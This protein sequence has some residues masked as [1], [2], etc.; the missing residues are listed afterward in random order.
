[1]TGTGRELLP[2]PLTSD[3]EERPMIHSPFA[4]LLNWY[5]TPEFVVPVLPAFGGAILKGL[6][7]RSRAERQDRKEEQE[8]RRVEWGPHR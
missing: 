1:M 2:R 8:L 7:A 6:D 4:E 3:S 5:L